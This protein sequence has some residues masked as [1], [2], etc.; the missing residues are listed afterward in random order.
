MRFGIITLV[1]DNY[2]NKFQ[3]YAVE[4]ILSRYGEVETFQLKGYSV[5]VPASQQKSL[6]QKLTPGYINQVL[7]S[8]MLYTYD[9]TNGAR[10]TL[11][12]TIY[13]LSH[14]KKLLQLQAK[15]KD[16]FSSFMKHHLHVSDR[17]ISRDNCS[18]TEF[19]EQYD[20]F[21]CGSDQIWNPTY[22]TTSELAFLS[23]AQ[24]KKK[25]VAL[26]PS[27]GVSNI[28]SYRKQD[29]ASWITG[30]DCLSVREEAGNRIIRNLTGREAVVLVDPTMMLNAS[31]W[32]N[33][34]VKPATSLPERYILGYF[35]G[36]RDKKCQKRIC[37]IA[38]KMDLP[39]VMLFDIESPE[40]YVYGPKEVL[41]AIDH[42]E[43]VI[44]D[45][46]HGSVFSIL[47]H[48]NFTIL[49]RNEGG[50]SMSSRL[51]TLMDKFEIRDLVQEKEARIPEKTWKVVDKKL[52]LER[53][54]WKNY[55]EKCLTP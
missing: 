30:I 18:E 7:K 5:P 20:C 8:R 36:M 42:A 53:E 1:S 38:K 4:T 2:G 52:D 28:P 13:G 46:F 26:A 15:R 22:Q 31:D 37:S 11:A 41:Y 21:C 55:L 44:T 25:T 10:S 32:R 50:A 48:K 16:A 54:K 34:A 27:F 17:V 43:H 19:I 39:I 35:L 47:F 23:F 40:Y 9:L 6:L 45:S 29:F 24:G 49:N 33:L 51:E 3:N 14:R 12:N